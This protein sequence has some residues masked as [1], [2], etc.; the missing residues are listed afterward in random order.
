M[1]MNVAGI[2]RMGFPQV[3]QSKDAIPSLRK[4]AIITNLLTANAL[5]Q[6]EGLKIIGTLSLST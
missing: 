1:M 4:G 6:F 5:A 3:G 2:T